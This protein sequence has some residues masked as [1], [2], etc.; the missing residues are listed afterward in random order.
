MRTLIIARHGKAEKAEFGTFDFKRKLMERGKEDVQRVSEALLKII[1]PEHIISSP[2]ER[3]FQTAKIFAK[4]CGIAKNDLELADS[5]YEASMASLLKVINEIDPQYKCVLIAGH[6]P[7]FE[8][9]IEYLSNTHIGHLPT[10][11]TAIIEFQLE[12][13]QLISAGTGS[14]RELI[15]P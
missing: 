4:N 5:I 9:A 7:A 6:N 2:A 11:G 3:A 12:N 14:L 8:F 13:W 1:T 10:A 15:V